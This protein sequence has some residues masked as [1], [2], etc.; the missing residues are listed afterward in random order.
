MTGESVGYQKALAIP[1]VNLSPEAC[2]SIAG[3]FRSLCQALGAAH[4]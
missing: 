4:A 2:R 3:A 1:I